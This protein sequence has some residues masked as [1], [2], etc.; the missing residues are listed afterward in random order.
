MTDFTAEVALFASRALSNRSR[1]GTVRGL[2][3]IRGD[4]WLESLDER[5]REPRE[6]RI[7]IFGLDRRRGRDDRSDDGG[8]IHRKRCGSVQDVLRSFVYVGECVGVVGIVERMNDLET[9]SNSRPHLRLKAA[10]KGTT[11]FGFGESS[12]AAEILG[13]GEECAV[14]FGE[15]GCAVYADANVFAGEL[16]HIGHGPLAVVGSSWI[17]SRNG[18]DKLGIGESSSIFGEKFPKFGGLD[19]DVVTGEGL[20]LSIWEDI[21]LLE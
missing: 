13:D 11:L 5:S 20:P 4:L 18:D 17:E 1:R 10:N 2:R 15:V 9:T 19:V 8:M 16:V 3:V 21:V 7:K 12:A 6:H 14:I